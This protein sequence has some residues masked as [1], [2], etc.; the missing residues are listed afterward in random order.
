M[1]LVHIA[2]SN[3]LY[4]SGWNLRKVLGELIDNHTRASKSVISLCVTGSGEYIGVALRTP[5]FMIGSRPSAAMMV[6]AFVRPQ[7]RG[8]KIG[9]A[10][11]IEVGIQDTDLTGQ[12][13]VG[14]SQFWDFCQHKHIPILDQDQE[15]DQQDLEPEK[16]YA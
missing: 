10:L 16:I 3:R 15:L 6:Q 14:S 11:C 5:M 4:V 2:I 13:I 12:G 1:Q 7:H 9:S 8:Q